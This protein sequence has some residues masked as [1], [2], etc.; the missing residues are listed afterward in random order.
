MRLSGTANS[1]GKTG[2]A[3]GVGYQW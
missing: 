3:A 2:V 1:Q